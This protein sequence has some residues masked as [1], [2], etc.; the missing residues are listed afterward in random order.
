MANVPQDLLDFL[1][2]P[3]N[4]RMTLPEGEVRRLELFAPGELTL[5]TF[6]VS[7]YELHLNGPNPWL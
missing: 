5:Q 6:I 4:R 7:S 1:T 2:K 3:E